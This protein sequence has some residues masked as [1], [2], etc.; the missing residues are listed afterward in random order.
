MLQADLHLHVMD[1]SQSFDAEDNQ[2]L[3]QLDP[4]KT[5]LLLN[6]QDLPIILQLSDYQQFTTMATCLL[7][8]QGI[9][10]LQQSM[11]M[12]LGSIAAMPPHAVVSERH[13]SYL[14]LARK[15]LEEAL[16]FLHTKREDMIVLASSK[17]RTAIES[18]G[19]IIGM[20]YHPDLLK[21]IFSKF[22]I[23]K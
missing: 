13:R 3:A 8:G 11:S 19:Q 15:E 10:K 16:A 5:I 18:I 21:A 9:E 23:G 12:M 14:L 2:T 20:T 4:K 6:K 1:V 7:T 22:C 17:I